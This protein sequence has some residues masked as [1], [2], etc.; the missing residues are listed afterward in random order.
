MIRLLG[1]AHFNVHGA[2]ARGDSRCLAGTAQEPPAHLALRLTVY[3]PGFLR[4]CPW[5]PGAIFNIASNESSNDLG[6]RRILLGAQALEHSLLARVDE[7]GKTGGAVFKNHGRP[8]VCDEV[9]RVA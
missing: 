9:H 5:L 2:R 8:L 7:N 4:R 1:A 3:F 6:R